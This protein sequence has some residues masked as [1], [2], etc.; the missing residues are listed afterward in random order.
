[1]KHL[2]LACMLAFMAACSTMPRVADRPGPD[3]FADCEDPP[4]EAIEPYLYPRKGT[5]T[6][7]ALTISGTPPASVVANCAYSFT[8]TVTSGTRVVTFA[9]SNKP[10]WASFS[11]AT[12]SLTGTPTSAQV[13][14]YADIGI[15]VT[16]GSTRVSLPFFTIT[17][18]APANIAPVISGTPPTTVAAGSAYFFK[19]TASDAN[20]D[21]LSFS[22]VNKP[23]WAGFSAT[24]GTLSGTPSSAQA[25]SYSG[26]AI[27]VSDG[28]AT[29]SLPPFLITVTSVTTGSAVLSWTPPTQNTDG[30]AIVNLAGYN[31]YYGTSATQLGNKVVVSNPGATSY[32]V[33]NLA[34]GTYYFAITAYT[35]DGVE[36]ALSNVSSKSIP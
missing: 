32:T 17:V 22:I 14:S 27:S 34:S 3:G 23:V 5:G 36:S 6:T 28:K 21:A 20:G 24:D 19:P 30:S 10:V 26:I 2:V 25:G 15:S 35:A 16:D 18:E 9:I 7:V 12:G 29:T 4:A 13:G 11:V 31:V 8:P 33:S 1:M